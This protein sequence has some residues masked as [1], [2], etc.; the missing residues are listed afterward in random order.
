[1]NPLFQNCTSFNHTDRITDSEPAY[2]M[3]EVWRD[4]DAS[5][6]G[7]PFVEL[8]CRSC[9]DSSDLLVDR[10]PRYEIA[11]GAYFA[12]V[13]YKLYC[14]SHKLSLYIPVDESILWKALNNVNEQHRFR[15]NK[16]GPPVVTRCFQLFRLHI[17]EIKAWIESKGFRVGNGVAMKKAVIITLRNGL[18]FTQPN[19][20]GVGFG[21]GFGLG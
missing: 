2:G 10:A 5:K 12:C 19:W 9:Y 16:Q 18:G 21:L 1:M 13:K 7:K 11:T 4:D 8:V 20:V 15:A 14:S 17:R 3:G 6:G